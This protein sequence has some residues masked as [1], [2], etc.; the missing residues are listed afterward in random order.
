MC[1]C[2]IREECSRH[3]QRVN[4]LESQLRAVEMTGQMGS[5]CVSCAQNEATAVYQLS[6]D[7]LTRSVSYVNVITL[8][9]PFQNKTII[10]AA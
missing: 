10:E 6:V 5:L 4:E 2:V 1:V 8:S 9:W 7:A 3:E